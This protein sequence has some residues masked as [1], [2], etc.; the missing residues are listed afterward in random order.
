GIMYNLAK[1]AFETD[2]TRAVTIMLDSVD[3]PALEIPG[4]KINDGYHNL[5]HHGRSEDK[6]SQ[7]KALDDLHM[8]LLAK[9]FS[10]LKAIREGDDPL[11]NRTMIYFGSNMGDANKHVNT[12]VPVIF[13]GGGFKHGQ[14]VAFDT[15][16][17]YPL[18]NLFVS[19]LQRMGLDQD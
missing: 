5:S 9:L 2:S 14:H 1:L 4:V 13:A 16:K 15:E 6:R 17:N 8:K 12:N 10:D 11:L 7:L 18:A 19:I 3:S